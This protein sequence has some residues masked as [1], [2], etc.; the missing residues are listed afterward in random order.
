MNWDTSKLEHSDILQI[1]MS[2]MSDLASDLDLDPDAKRSIRIRLGRKVPDQQ[3]IFLWLSGRVSWYEGR[4]DECFHC[5]GGLRWECG[6]RWS[7]WKEH[8]TKGGG[9][10]CIDNVVNAGVAE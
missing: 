5:N 6:Q 2:E 9:G 10:G 1:F 4:I 3:L 8:K 7:W